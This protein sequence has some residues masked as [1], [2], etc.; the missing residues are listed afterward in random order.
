[1]RNTEKAQ[2]CVPEKLCVFVFFLSIVYYVRSI[3]VSTTYSRVCIHRSPGPCQHLVFGAMMRECLCTS[4]H[5]SGRRKGSTSPIW[6]GRGSTWR[7]CHE[8]VVHESMVCRG[9]S[10]LHLRAASRA[11]VKGMLPGKLRHR[12][13]GGDGHGAEAIATRSSMFESSTRCVIGDNTEVSHRRIAAPMENMWQRVCNGGTLV[14]N[15]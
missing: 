15:A 7:G 8:V 1:M 9:P 4:P 13:Q 6:R 10:L 11:M 14:V 5:S 3:G 2:V 12:R